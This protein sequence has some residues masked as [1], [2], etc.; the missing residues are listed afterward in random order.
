[1]MWVGRCRIGH[2]ECIEMVIWQSQ[3]LDLFS[4]WSVCSNIIRRSFSE[5]THHISY[6]GL[7]CDE[8]GN[9]ADLDAQSVPNWGP[10]FAD[11]N[12]A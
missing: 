3:I 5:V 12:V 11:S 6:R 8:S 9:G 2:L 4:V 1:M 7:R 10:E